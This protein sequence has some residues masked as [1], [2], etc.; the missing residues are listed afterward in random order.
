MVVKGMLLKMTGQPVFIPL[1][2][3]I[4][5]MMLR[6]NIRFRAFYIDTK[7]NDLAEALRNRVNLTELSIPGEILVSCPLIGMI[8]NFPPRR[9]A[10]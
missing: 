3:E 6:K 9:F 4:Y 2:K 8:G 5:I 1:L 7:E 10:N